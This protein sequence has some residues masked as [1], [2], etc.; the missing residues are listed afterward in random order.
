MTY[1][2]KLTLDSQNHEI[3]QQRTCH[4]LQYRGMYYHIVM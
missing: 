2:R 3:K 1:D 4:G